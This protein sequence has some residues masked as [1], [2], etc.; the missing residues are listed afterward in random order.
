MWKITYFG[1]KSGQDLK[2][3]AA[4]AHQEFPGV[5][6]SPR[7][8]QKRQRFI[9]LGIAKFSKISSRKFSFHLT[10]LLLFVEIKIEYHTSSEI[11]Q[12]SDL[13]QTF[14]ENFR[15]I[16]HRFHRHFRKFWSNGKS[17]MSV[18]FKF[19]KRKCQQ[20]STRAL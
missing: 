10:L 13:L 19:F 16:Y 2:N 5:P 8:R 3:G 15:S 17:P 18:I 11:Q 1:Q 14:L 7:P 12:F 6:K 20:I 9:S 4:H